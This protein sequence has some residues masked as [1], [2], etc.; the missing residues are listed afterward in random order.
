[1]LRRASL[2][3]ISHAVSQKEKAKALSAEEQAKVAK[4]AAAY[5]APTAETFAES[6]NTM[7]AVDKALRPIVCRDAR[8]LASPR[9]EGHVI[10]SCS[11]NEA[12]LLAN[13]VRRRIVLDEKAPALIL[14]LL[15]VA[16][17]ERCTLS[18]AHELLGIDRAL[19]VIGSADHAEALG[20]CAVEH[21]R[22]II[23][24]LGGSGRGGGADE[25]IG[26]VGGSRNGEDGDG[27]TGSSEA[28]AKR[29]AL[30]AARDADLAFQFSS[31]LRVLS[32]IRARRATAAA[33]RHARALAQAQAAPG[34]SGSAA[35]AAA[36]VRKEAPWEGP[37]VV[38]E[39]RAMDDIFLI[40]TTATESMAQLEAEKT[41]G[42]PESRE[43]SSRLLQTLRTAARSASTRKMLGLT[44][45]DDPAGGAAAEGPAAS[46]PPPS[47]RAAAL[48]VASDVVEGAAA[49]FSTAPETSSPRLQRRVIS[50]RNRAE[51][52]GAT[53]SPLAFSTAIWS[54]GNLYANS[55]TYALL[56]N[57]YYCP[58]SSSV[59]SELLSPSITRGGSVI[60]S[61]DVP[62]R[63]SRLSY[64]DLVE[65]LRLKHDA[66]AIGLYRYGVPVRDGPGGPR[67]YTLVHPP[68]STPLYS[69]SDGHDSVFVL[70][71]KHVLL[72]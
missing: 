8:T 22:S 70:A 49:A 29:S 21:A 58:M 27:V 71:H 24:S 20:R 57:F 23:L 28:E 38:L 50:P 68:P 64:A 1:M 14:L 41:A 34:S 39:L 11:I 51:I 13:A 26:Y 16:D 54:G 56:A 43:G 45:M 4:A 55:L 65:E 69:S 48:G 25:D 40:D 32:K 10:I 52:E 63:F 12:A 9:A 19:I 47:Q 42:I 33:A 30:L 60:E 66:V 17:L 3:K 44:T 35:S 59:L 31:V 15:K 62:K 18:Q 5:V 2:H 53:G 6:L 7:A 36:K 37:T 46:L 61:V 67:R 72:E